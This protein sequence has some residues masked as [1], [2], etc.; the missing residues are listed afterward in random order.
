MS[1]WPF[2]L[3]SRSGNYEFGNAVFVCVCGGVIVLF[4][5]QRIAYLGDSHNGQ[6]EKGTARCAQQPRQE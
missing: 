4:L 6:N 2:A 5:T 1:G 3:E